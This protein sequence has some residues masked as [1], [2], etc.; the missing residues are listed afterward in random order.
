MA[1][2]GELCLSSGNR[3]GVSQSRRPADEQRRYGSLVR[4]DNFDAYLMDP[5]GQQVIQLSSQGGA[6]LAAWNPDSDEL[7]VRP[8]VFGGSFGTITILEF[9][10]A[11]NQP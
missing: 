7:A 9:P 4:A 3:D 1:T 6:G 10:P 8:Q 11:G 2:P 5:A